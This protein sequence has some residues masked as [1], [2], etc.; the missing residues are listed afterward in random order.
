MVTINATPKSPTANSY[1]T[2]VRANTILTEERLYSSAWT[3]AVDAAQKTSIVWATR[4]IDLCFQFNGYPTTYTQKL[5]NPRTG[6]RDK[7]GRYFDINVIPEFLEV[8]T[9][10]LALELIKRDR[11]AEP[12]LLGLG[13]SRVRV[14][15]A[16]DVSIK[17][18]Q[19]IGMIPQTIVDML[20]P[21][22]VLIVGSG[23][24][25]KVLPL[26]RV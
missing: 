12:E 9:A 19:T 1:V 8:A 24:N 21:F 17:D 11:G 3:A 5:S 14:G 4:L 16:V 10:C 13:I 7:D 25:F 23:S 2:Q 15:N 26:R 22:A 6:L 20:T 18:T